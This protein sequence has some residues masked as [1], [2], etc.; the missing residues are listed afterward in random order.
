MYVIFDENSM[1]WTLLS[2]KGSNSYKN[3]K[4]SII[5]ESSHKCANGVL[6]T[7]SHL[8]N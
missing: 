7:K 6:C 2:A 4:K 5:L 8:Y 1:E 3:R